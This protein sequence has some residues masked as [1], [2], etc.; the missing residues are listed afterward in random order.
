MKGLFQTIL[1]LSLSII[2]CAQNKKELVLKD[3]QVDSLFLLMEQ[4]EVAR[5]QM[6]NQYF[7]SRTEK[8]LAQ[9]NLKRLDS[10]LTIYKK[11]YFNLVDSLFYT[12]NQPCLVYTKYRL[13]EVIDQLGNDSLYIW[14]FYLYSNLTEC[15]RY[16]E[17]YKYI[18][19]RYDFVEFDGSS[20][21]R[22]IKFKYKEM[23][24]A[25][26]ELNFDSAR[27][28]QI[29]NVFLDSLP[30]G[31]KTASQLERLAI[32]Y[33]DYYRFRKFVETKTDYQKVYGEDYLKP[34]DLILK[35]DTLPSY[36]IHFHNLKAV[37]IEGIESL[38]DISILEKCDSLMFLAIVAQEITP[39]MLQSIS[40]MNHLKQLV[41]VQLDKKDGTFERVLKLK[42]KDIKK[43][44]SVSEVYMNISQ[45]KLNQYMSLY[46]NWRVKLFTSDARGLR[47]ISELIDE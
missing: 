20:N 3:T 27:Y 29:W 18:W 2:T 5:K 37:Y 16:L 32:R 12:A 39:T 11:G 23:M 9:G 17:P 6:E 34:K 1:L 19:L 8:Y 28:V 38:K 7:Q 30:Q 44:T 36:F 46:P 45:K 35:M 25:L 33:N 13:P 47:L 31:L 14:D 24:N 40:K 15:I 21:E 26:N 41:L 42:N 22:E 43:L 10:I 4:C